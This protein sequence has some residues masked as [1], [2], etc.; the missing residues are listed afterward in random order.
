MSPP[1]FIIDLDTGI[2]DAMALLVAL[3]AHK[4]GRICIEAITTVT[5]NTAREN[6]VKNTYRLLELVNQTEVAYT[7]M[8]TLVDSRE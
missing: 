3:H 2:D 6:V 7:L 1:K 5:G 4:E 8:V